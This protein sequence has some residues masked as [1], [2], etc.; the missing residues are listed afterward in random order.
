MIIMTIEIITKIAI[1]MKITMTYR[2]NVNNG[3]SNSVKNMNTENKNKDKATHTHIHT[4][5]SSVPPIFDVALCP[6]PRHTLSLLLRK[7]LD[8][9][10]AALN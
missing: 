10:A 2:N 7:P 3:K 5:Q 9:L 1:I 8:P 4:T 6:P